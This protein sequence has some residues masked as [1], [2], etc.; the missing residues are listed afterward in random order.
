MELLR[1]K[2]IN[3]EVN[4]LILETDALLESKEIARAVEL[5]HEILAIEPGYAMAHNYL[6]WVHTHF[7]VDYAQAKEHL[8]LA[9]LFDPNCH[10]AYSN[11]AILLQE[12]NA[13]EELELLI[14]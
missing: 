12:M 4:S 9:I 14:T 10:A 11:M 8:R 5:L 13:F 2:Q 3:H 1:N 7:L 6:G